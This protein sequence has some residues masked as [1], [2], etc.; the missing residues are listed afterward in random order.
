[1]RTWAGLFVLA[2]CLC[3]AATGCKVVTSD[4]PVGGGPAML[5]AAEWDGKWLANGGWGTIRVADAGKG[6]LEVTGEQQ[7]QQMSLTLTVR[8]SGKWLFVNLDSDAL[9]QMMGGGAGMT[10]TKDPNAPEVYIWGYLKNDQNTI[11]FW[12][13][14]AEKF[15]ALVEAGKLKGEVKAE[16]QN[17][18]VALTGLT[19]QQLEMIMSETEGVLFDWSNPM[20]MIREPESESAAPSGMPGMQGTPGMPE[21]TPST[22]D[23]ESISP[24]MKENLRKLEEEMRTSEAEARKMMEEARRQAEEGLKE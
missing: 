20:V 21:M 23:D 10:A 16:D 3:V 14:D 15:K 12:L 18:E 24:Q 6:L 5:N 4:K 2:G 1:M 7:G 13:P 19:P 9:A 17:L 11:L 22:G 8:Q